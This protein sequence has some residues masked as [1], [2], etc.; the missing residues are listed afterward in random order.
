[1]ADTYNIKDPLVVIGSGPSLEFVDFNI[2]QD[3]DTFSI[4]DACYSYEKMNWYPKYYGA[5]DEDWVDSNKKQI[6]KI[7]DSPISNLF[8]FNDTNINK[9]DNVTLIE[10]QFHHDIKTS[11][12]LW[13]PWHETIETAIDVIKSENDITTLAAKNIIMRLIGNHDLP[14]SILASGI[15]KTMRGEKLSP[16]D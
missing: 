3:F 14:P 16:E 10:K 13:V 8:F 6:K 5:F 12:E 9:K 1:M 15:I 4:N 2:L 11:L 7:I